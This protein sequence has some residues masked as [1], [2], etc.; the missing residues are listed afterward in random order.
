L[1]ARAVKKVHHLVPRVLF[2]GLWQ[3]NWSASAVFDEKYEMPERAGAVPSER[4]RRAETD[5]WFE[6]LLD[7]RA[8]KWLIAITLFGPGA[9]GSARR[10]T[11]LNVDEQFYELG[12]GRPVAALPARVRRG[13]FSA[14]LPQGFS[15]V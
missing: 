6:P 4:G 1:D 11:I 7:R 5:E 2:R 14:S 9:D 13:R 8:F 12:S 3:L 10:G 15:F